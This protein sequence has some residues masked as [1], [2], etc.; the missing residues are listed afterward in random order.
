MADDSRRPL[1]YTVTV[2]DIYGE[3]RQLSGQLSTSITQQE[4][5]RQKLDDHESRI[6]ALEA[7]RYALPVSAVSAVVAGIAAVASAFFG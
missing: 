4:V 5:S 6:R 3:L 7:W 2:A 1:G